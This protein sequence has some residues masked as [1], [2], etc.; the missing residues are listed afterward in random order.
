MTP[1]DGEPSQEGETT[2]GRIAFRQLVTFHIA[3]TSSRMNAQAG[4]I[5]AEFDITLTQWRLIALVANEGADS[6]RE[7]A[8]ISSIDKGLLSRNLNT[9]IEK[10]LMTRTSDPD[11][12]RLKR[13][14]LTAKGARLHEKALPVMMRRYARLIRDF[15]EAELDALVKALEILE[16]AAREDEFGLEDLE[17]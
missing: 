5:L 6:L 13:L 3:R 9:L 15:D 10:G 17:V 16:E 4:R 11:D 14:A 7:I 1:D 2:G 8:E 12:R